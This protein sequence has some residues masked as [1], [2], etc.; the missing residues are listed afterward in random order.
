MKK[1]KSVLRKTKLYPPTIISDCV[2]RTHIIENL[3][4]NYRKKILTTIVAP[5][6]YGKSQLASYW[7]NDL[8]VKSIWISLEKNDDDLTIFL[9]YLVE[10][11]DKIF[12]GKIKQTQEYLVSVDLPSI[13]V[14]AHTLVNELDSIEEEFIVVLDDYH[15][16]EENLI[17]SIING[18]LQYPPENM[19]LCIV[20]RKDPPLNISKLRAYDRMQEIRMNDL[21]FV[22]DEIPVLYKNMLNIDIDDS[23]SKT[24]IEK[25]EGWITGLRLAALSGSTLDELK[26]VLKPLHGSFGLVAEYLLEEVLEKQSS[27]IKTYLMCTSLLNRF[28]PELIDT[29]LGQTKTEKTNLITGKTFIEWLDSSNLFIIS[30]DDKGEWYRYH[31]EFQTLLQKSLKMSRKE[32]EINEFYFKASKW[33]EENDYIEEAIEHSLAGGDSINAAEIIERNR[34]ITKD[35][36]IGMLYVIGLI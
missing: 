21:S 31:N 23:L 22:L 1:V 7:L 3:N 8:K 9:Q 16:I 29:I 2:P 24:L 30:L 11:I 4:K 19:H 15:V 28:C 6:G 17:H 18:L 5:A 12:K 27:E 26:E 20:T 10:S 25:T 13:Q 35:P 32:K 36:D 14:I 34:I 33:F